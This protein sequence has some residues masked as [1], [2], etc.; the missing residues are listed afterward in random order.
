MPDPTAI[1][2]SVCTTDPASTGG[3]CANPAWMKFS[4]L[5]AFSVSQLD[6]ASLGA[7]FGA[8]L[9]LVATGFV[10]GHAVALLVNFIHSLSGR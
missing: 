10:I 5:T 3:M 4:D 1:Y 6:P 2:L 8:G 9:S 7:A